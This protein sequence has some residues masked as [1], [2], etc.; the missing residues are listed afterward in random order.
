VQQLESSHVLR[1][2]ILAGRMRLQ[3]LRKKVWR[4]ETTLTSPQGKRVRLCR[5][6]HDV[7]DTHFSFQPEQWRRVGARA[8]NQ[9]AFLALVLDGAL[10]TCDLVEQELRKERRADPLWDESSLWLLWISALVAAFRENNLES[11]RRTST[12][13]VVKREFISFVLRLQEQAL[14]EPTR[15]RITYE[16]VRKGILAALP[17]SRRHKSFDLYKAF[18][19][20]IAVGRVPPDAALRGLM[21]VIA[22]YKKRNGSKSVSLI[23]RS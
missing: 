16:S 20:Q 3:A 17:Y 21:R 7:I 1:Q 11:T 2:A 14:R 22:R 6:V 8:S 23:S 12:G 5:G 13:V 9:L 15:V 4:Y 18:Y 19:G 10:A